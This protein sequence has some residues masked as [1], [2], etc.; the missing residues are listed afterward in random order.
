M[1][2]DFNQSKSCRVVPRFL[3]KAIIRPIN[4]KEL[5]DVH[6]HVKVLSRVH[7]HSSSSKFY[8]ASFIMSESRLK[9]EELLEPSTEFESDE[10]DSDDEEE[11]LDE[12]FR[13]IA[14]VRQADA[15]LNRLAA[16]LACA[17]R[18]ERQPASTALEAPIGDEPADTTVIAYAD[19]VGRILHRGRSVADELCDVQGS[20]YTLKVRRRKPGERL[21]LVLAFDNRPPTDGRPWHPPIVLEV[22]TGAV[23]Q[24]HG[25]AWS[26]ASAESSLSVPSV[27]PGDHLLS[28]NGRRATATQYTT[29]AA[30]FT[31]PGE[32]E[33]SL[34]LSRPAAPVVACAAVPA[35]VS[36]AKEAEEAPRRLV[37]PLW[38]RCGDFFYRKRYYVLEDGLLTYTAARAAPTPLHLGEVRAA[39]VHARLYDMS[40]LPEPNRPRH[41]L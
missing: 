36:A 15:L 32:V 6:V 16:R 17:E 1:E 29:C 5:R 23:D 4:Q 38:K 13:S 2:G 14:G 39:L 41:G 31:P 40:P 9:S 33:L 8:P 34:L 20:E 26:S 30:L 21:G 10:S 7:I 12:E 22:E 24:P 28:V 37:G 3:T 25:A 18:R 35:A 11:Q 19:G 27:R